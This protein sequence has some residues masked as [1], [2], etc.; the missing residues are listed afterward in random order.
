MQRA[1]EQQR[2]CPMKRRRKQRHR[3]AKH[4]QIA[5]KMTSEMD[6][7]QNTA[8]QRETC[9]SHESKLKARSGSCTNHPPGSKITW[10]NILRFSRTQGRMDG[11]GQGARASRTEKGGVAKRLRDREAWPPAP[12]PLHTPLSRTFLFLLCNERRCFCFFVL[13]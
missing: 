2:Y 5:Q 4:Q 7:R 8:P 12:P 9:F 3:E 13:L 10:T 6:L 1:D 11:W